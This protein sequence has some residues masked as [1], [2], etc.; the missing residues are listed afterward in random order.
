MNVS[1]AR[2]SISRSSRRTILKRML[3]V[4]EKAGRTEMASGYT[5]LGDMKIFC[6]AYSLYALND[7][8]DYPP[9]SQPLSSSTLDRFSELKAG[10]NVHTIPVNRD[11]LR[12]ILNEARETS[13]KAAAAIKSITLRDGEFEIC[14]NVMYLL[15]LINMFD[16]DEI[17]CDDCP[18]HPAFVYGKDGEWGMLCSVRI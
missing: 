16:A 15:D 6:N 5:P 2:K 1:K 8:M 17:Q 3:R 14:F 9:M 11:T 13:G 10:A 4:A 7:S 18:T 12:T